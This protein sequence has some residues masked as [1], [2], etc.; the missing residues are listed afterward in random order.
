MGQSGLLLNVP[1]LVLKVV[2]GFLEGLGAR[3]TSSEGFESQFELPVPA[4]G[5]KAEDVGLHGCSFHMVLKGQSF[6]AESVYT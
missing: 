3:V 1:V 4:D 6:H 5:R 2:G